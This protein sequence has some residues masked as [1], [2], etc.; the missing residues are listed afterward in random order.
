MRCSPKPVRDGRRAF[1][2]ESIGKTVGK[3]A[4]CMKSA[5]VSVVPTRGETNCCFERAQILRPTEESNC[6][7]T[8]E[9]NTKGIA[10]ISQSARDLGAANTQINQSGFPDETQLDNNPA[11]PLGN[12]NSVNLSNNLQ[13]CAGLGIPTP[14]PQTGAPAKGNR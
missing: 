5:C 6:P 9:P 13:T 12:Q 1:G 3:Q 8:G 2:A 7:S 11:Q 14:S 4:A 10:N